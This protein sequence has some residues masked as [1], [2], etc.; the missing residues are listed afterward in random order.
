MQA[1]LRW[2]IRNSGVLLFILLEGICF[3]LIIRFNEVQNRIYLN[4]TRQWTGAV[5]ELSANVS[6]YFSLG[7]ENE[8]LRQE[9][10]RLRAR[11]ENAYYDGRI[12]IDT[13]IDE[14]LIPQF[15]YI[16]AEVIDN[17]IV[18]NNNFLTLNRGELHGIQP[19]MGVITDEGVVGIVREVSPHFAAVMSIL[20]RQ[21][22]ISAQIKGS[23]YFGTLVWSGNDPRRM[24]LEANPKHAEVEVGDTIVTSGYSNVFPEGHIIGYVDAVELVS[25]DNFFRIQ[26]RLSEQMG[27]ISTVYVVRNLFAEEINSIEE[28]IR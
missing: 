6:G 16:P 3:Y 7:K 2:F 8:A 24:R 18:N 26:I 25:G 19:H 5:Y 9:N 21:T 10:A 13:I 4:S 23:G 11:L 20:H 1:L 14:S 28:E 17:S 27:S 15:E 22:R 12:A